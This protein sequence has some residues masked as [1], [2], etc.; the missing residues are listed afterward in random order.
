MEQGHPPIKEDARRVA[1]TLSV[2]LFLPPPRGMT[3]SGLP[4]R[5][6]GGVGSE[7]ESGAKAE[8]C[9]AALLSRVPQLRSSAGADYLS[10]N[11]G[12]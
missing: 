10:R 12:R 3:I 4:Y 5:G 7:E 11:T 2:F 8:Y 6:V 9:A 1:I